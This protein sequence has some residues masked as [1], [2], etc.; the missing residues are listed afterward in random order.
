MI[1]FLGEQW[2]LD[3]Y[4]NTHG[5]DWLEVWQRLKG[6]AIENPE[7][8]IIAI[9]DSGVNPIHP[10]LIGK[11]WVNA[12][13]IPGDGVDNDGNGYIDD[14]HGCAF[15]SRT[16]SCAAINDDTL[17]QHGTGTTGIIAANTNNG[18]GIAGEA[19][20]VNAK[21]MIIKVIQSSGVGNYS[22][23]AAG[24]EYALKNNAQ[25]VV[26]NFAGWPISPLTRADALLQELHDN[27]GILIA[28]SG[29]SNGSEV[30]VGWPA[31]NT[32]VIAVGAYGKDGN[33][34][35]FSSRGTELSIVAP[36]ERITS[37]CYDGTEF[38]DYCIQ[39]GTSF[40]GPQVVAA[41]ALA[42]S[43]RP[44]LTPDEFRQM[45]EEAGGMQWTPELGYGRLNFA[46]LADLLGIKEQFQIFLPL[47][48]R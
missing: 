13:E 18:I 46:R 26:M 29:N 5:T 37:T 31:R 45:L 43:V 33:I 44:T 1:H 25:I 21:V 32:N 12:G 36:G 9:L 19:S 20:L 17:V 38:N 3:S 2:Y 4:E 24:L 16:V 7:P 6:Q 27:G 8:I 48:V 22:D 42:R 39:S 30:G 23:I 35:N 41:A 14:E 47:V 15:I 40:A 28:G 10:E 34:L 11:R